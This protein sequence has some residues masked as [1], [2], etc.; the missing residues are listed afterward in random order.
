MQVTVVSCVS[1]VAV[2]LLAHFMLRARA[3]YMVDFQVY[4][5]PVRYD[6]DALI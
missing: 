3:I 4:R 2:A 6:H 1:L 5:P